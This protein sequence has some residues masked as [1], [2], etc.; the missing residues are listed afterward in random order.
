MKLGLN[1]SD[2]WNE[3]GSHIGRF[4][5]KT[6]ELFV[7]KYLSHISRCAGV[8]EEVLFPYVNELFDL[9]YLY[10]D[11]YWVNG[12]EGETKFIHDV[13]DG[14]VFG[15]LATPINFVVE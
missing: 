8:P 11:K 15:K 6:N 2:C 5:T 1:T 13:I 10:Y 4:F 3:V 12:H 9:G 7:P 14:K